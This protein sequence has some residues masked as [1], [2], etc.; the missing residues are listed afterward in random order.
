MTQRH[1]GEDLAGGAAANG[2]VV[3]ELKA[4]CEE[5]RVFA[6]QPAKAKARQ[7]VTFAHGTEADCALVDFACR[8]KTIRGVVLEFAVDFVAKNEDA[9]ATGEFHDMLEDIGRHQESGRVMGRVDVDDFRVGLNHF[10]QGG[11]IM[12]PAVL[13]TPGPFA[14]LR[15]GAPRNF[16]GALVARNLHNDVIAG[17]DKRVIENKDAF[18]GG[19]HGENVFRLD[20]PVDPRDSLPQSW[21]SR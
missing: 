9:A 5:F 13:I 4:A 12:D 3:L 1:R 2:G 8:G 11:E 15:S 18:L 19:G 21:H 6:N 16:E 14:D 20:S 17:S 7:A 10:L